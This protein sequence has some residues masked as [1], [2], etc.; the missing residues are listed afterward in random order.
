MSS[1]RPPR[2]ALWALERILPRGLPRAAILGDLEEEME[3]RAVSTSPAA[4]RRWYARQALGI[5]VRFLAR[6]RAASTRT[7]GP[8]VL[9]S[10]MSSL[11]AAARSLA[12]APA[13]T[14]GAALTLAVGVGATTAIF[15]VVDGVLLRPLAYPRPDELL[16]LALARQD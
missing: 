6:P 15:S 9:R 3:R 2:W 12:H 4:A 7:G 16:V 13:F 11:G 14:L 10:L 5:A 8:P 1:P